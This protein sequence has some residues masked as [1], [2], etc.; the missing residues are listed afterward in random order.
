MKQDLRHYLSEPFTW[1]F[2]CFFRPASLERDIEIHGLGKS[3]VGHRIMC[4]LRLT[5]PMF[6]YAYAL[7]LVVRLCLYSL[8]PDL[9][10]SCYLVE[11]VCVANPTMANIL[12]IAAYNTALGIVIGIVIGSASS[13]MLGMTIGISLGIALGVAKGL[14]GGITLGITFGLVEGI[15]LGAGGGLL[16]FIAWTIALAMVFGI[17]GNIALGSAAAIAGCMALSIARGIM[18]NAQDRVWSRSIAAV[19]TGGVGGGIVW[20]FAGGIAWFLVRDIS[21]FVSESTFAIYASIAFIISYILGC[22]RLPLYPMSCLSVLTAYFASRR[23]PQQVFAYLHGSALYWDEYLLLPLPGLKQ[24]LLNAAR[25]DG[26]SEKVL[27]EIEFIVTKRPR[28]I[29][30]ARAATL[31][32]TLD[33][34]EKR[35]TLDSIAKASEQFTERIPHEAQPIDPQ[36]TAVFRRLQDVCGDAARYRSPLLISRRRRHNLLQDMLVSLNEIHPDTASRDAVL[37]KRLRDLVN[38]WLTIVQAELREQTQNFETTGQIPNPYNPGPILEPHDRLFVGRSDLVRQLENALGQGRRRPTFFLYGERRMGKSSTLLQLPDLLTSRYLSITYDLQNPGITS[39]T[40]ALLHTIAEGI[41]Q[42]MEDRETPVKKL[43]RADLQEASKENLAATYLCFDEWLKGIERWLEQEDRMLL[44]A[45]DEFEKLEEARQDR[46]LMINLLLDWFRSVIQHRP[47]LALLF[48]GVR[49]FSEMEGDWAGYFVNVQMLKVSF[50]QQDEALDLITR[51]VDGFPSDEIFGEGVV[52]EILR[53]TGHH[54]FL[55]QAVCAKLID[56]LNA[57]NRDR[58]N[59]QDVAQ[60]VDKVLENWWDGYFR[61]L[62]ARTTTE[63][64]ACLFALNELGA[65]DIAAIRQHCEL[66]ERT[67]HRT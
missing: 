51:P 37:N 7:T 47:R 35:K 53:V 5:L 13:I 59:V 61:D 34:L 66:D 33:D 24:I 12:S 39:T 49:T 36:W 29:T 54:P 17:V 67:V 2:Y 65:G 8:F 40:V 31:E 57:D 26:Y 63:Q 14:A 25:L 23:N 44:L 28:Q 46:N 19:I 3:A 30:A 6:L 1:L 15:V 42:M 38:Q 55:I 58:A 32:I 16:L 41:Y 50:L 56:N 64:R 20:L 11:T 45:F 60:A 62:W 27:Q 18:G 48:S 21:W 4:M 43:E 9:V 10:S 22:Y 52:E